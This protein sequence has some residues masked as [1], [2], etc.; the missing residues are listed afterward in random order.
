MSIICPAKCFTLLEKLDDNK[1]LM[2]H[3]FI[4]ILSNSTISQ[5][6]KTS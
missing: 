3:I 4:I 5:I 1:I 6:G 2:Y